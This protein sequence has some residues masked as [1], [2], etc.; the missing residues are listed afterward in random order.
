MATKKDQKTDGPNDQEALN[1][2]VDAI[3]DPAL[4]DPEPAPAKGSKVPPIDIFKDAPPAVAQAAK[5]A[6]EVS[7]DLLK[8]V[9]SKAIEEQAAPAV[10]TKK[11]KIT[12]APKS[13]KSTKTIKVAPT[14]E[15]VPEEASA[16]SKPKKNK[17]TDLDD[18]ETDRA[19]DDIAAKEADTLLALQDAIGRKATRV[20]G[21]LAEDDK[22]V[23]RRRNRTIMILLVI[24]VA[25][26]LLAVP[27]ISYTCH[28]PIG[29]RLRFT[30]DIL[31]SV[32][33]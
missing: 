10:S 1:R 3:M 18:K 22:R 17:T 14:A 11:P 5:T 7:G 9:D 29:I 32:C 24:A 8:D 13:E 23:A 31:P 6:P 16:P 21:D 4:P 20:A 30:T 33:K 19:V 12:S 27:H 28:W 26:F 25:L 15:P 2:R